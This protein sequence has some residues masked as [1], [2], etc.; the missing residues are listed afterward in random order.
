MEIQSDSAATQAPWPARTGVSRTELDPVSFLHRSAAVHLQRVAVVDGERRWTYAELRE[1]VNGV[2]SALRDR[3]LERHDRVAALC[4][5]VPALL[6]LHHAVPA[7]SS[8]TPS[9][10]DHKHHPAGRSQEVHPANA[11]VAV[12]GPIHRSGSR[13]LRTTARPASS[14]ATGARCPAGHNGDVTQPRPCL[15]PQRHPEA[16]TIRVL[17]ARDAGRRFDGRYTIP[18][19]TPPY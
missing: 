10:A 16:M 17:C 12:E 1:R 18:T 13:R 2:A 6:E 15:R 19:E 9:S 14:P 3:G 8:R 5:N 4:P 7:H 11:W